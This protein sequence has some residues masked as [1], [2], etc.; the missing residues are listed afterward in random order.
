MKAVLPKPVHESYRRYRRQLISQI[1]LPMVIAGLLFVALI[2]LIIFAT[3]RENGDVARWAAISTIW[4]VIPIMIA[5]LI[6]LIVLGGLVYLMKRL[7]SITPTY[8]GMAQDFVHKLMIRIRLIADKLVKPVIF[9]D[10]VGASI[11]RL[12]GRR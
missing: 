8:T 3:F 11:N 9:L 6:F 2:V 10:S 7:L 4:I 12:I 1:I 5:S